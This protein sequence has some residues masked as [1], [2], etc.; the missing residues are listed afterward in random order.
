MWEHFKLLGWWEPVGLLER[1]RLSPE[2]ARALS[3]LGVEL[4]RAS[5]GNRGAN[6]Q[7]A[8]ACFEAA[9][10][11]LT[12]T[13]FPRDWALTQNNLGLA[14][15]DVPSGNRDA[16]LRKAIACYEAALRVLTETDF[17]REYKLVLENQRR[18]QSNL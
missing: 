12:E 4:W 18:A 15:S 16:N 3:A 17:P 9:L 10:R 14:W 5:L 7:Q 8:I 13:C 2:E 1:P 6:L 11:V